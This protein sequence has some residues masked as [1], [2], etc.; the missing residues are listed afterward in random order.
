M[1]ISRRRFV[2]S[3]AVALGS[4][5]MTAA[6]LA[7]TPTMVSESDPMAQ[8]LGYKANASTVDRS[9]FSQYASGQTCSNCL[10]YQGK[11]GDVSGPCPL[12]AGKSVAA[13]GWC[14][15]YAKKA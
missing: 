9:K 4:L 10:L 8:A 14:G 13:Q 5:A 15:S 6:A 12:Y 11:S 1:Y 7:D 2:E 3:S